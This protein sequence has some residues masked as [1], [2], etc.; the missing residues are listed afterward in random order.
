[1]R[2]SKK[3]VLLRPQLSSYEAVLQQLIAEASETGSVIEIQPSLF[4]YET[5]V[6]FFQREKKR[7]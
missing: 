5:E 4:G 3:V 6:N 1:M 7:K 2:L